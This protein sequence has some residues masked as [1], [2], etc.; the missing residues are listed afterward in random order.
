VPLG[1]ERLVSIADDE[2]R[3]GGVGVGAG[4]EEDIFFPLPTNPEQLEIAEKLTHRQGVL[5]QGPPGTGKSHSIANLICHLLAAGQRVLITSHTARALTVLKKKI[6]EEVTALCVSLLGND[7]AALQAL[8]DSVQEITDRYNTWNPTGNQTEIQ[9]LMS[10]I[11]TLKQATEKTQQDLRSLREQE[12]YKHPPMFGNYEGTMQNIALRVQAEKSQLGWVDDQPE[13]D[14]EV[15]LESDKPLRLLNLLREIDPKSEADALKSVIAQEN[16]PEPDRF[17]LLVRAEKKAQDQFDEADDLRNHPAYAS[18]K[19][20]ERDLRQ[21]LCGRLDHL[22]THIQNLKRDA[23]VQ[24]WLDRAIQ[25]ILSEQHSPWDTLAQI[26]R[27]RLDKVGGISAGTNR[28]EVEGLTEDRSLK[29]VLAHAEDL[30]Y[31][32]EAGGKLRTL[33]LFLTKPAREAE[34]LVKNMRVGGR[35]CDNL[36]TLQTFKKPGILP[37]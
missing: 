21:G 6:P 31:H 36:E 18:L 32:L 11:D 1:V 35:L 16:L 29:T 15:P 30:L 34:Y 14:Q 28:I 25:E 19:T 17:G 3:G 37:E 10:E 9:R 4:E 26:S 5:V 23:Q 27:E 33:G 12:T 2:G 20:S 8:E 7:R 24:P 13:E 22:L